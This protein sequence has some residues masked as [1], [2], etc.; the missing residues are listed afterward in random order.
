MRHFLQIN[1]A[2]FV[3]A[4]WDYSSDRARKPPGSKDVTGRTDGPW[5][6]KKYD[7]A[8]DT[9]AWPEPTASLTASASSIQLGGKVTLSWETSHAVSA[10]IS[11]TGGTVIHRCEPV[12]AGAVEVEPGRTATYTLTATGH[13]G[14]T[15]ATDRVTVTVS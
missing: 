13:P 15:P 2:G 5:L 6:G 7:R 8:A 14:A 1:G 3:T 10:E 9:F 12:Q 4:Q 11:V